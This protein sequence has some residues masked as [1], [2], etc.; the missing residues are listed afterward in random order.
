MANGLFY[1]YF[2]DLREVVAELAGD[3]FDELRARTEA[4]DESASDY[5]WLYRNHVNVVSLFA[6]N[7]GIL[8]CLFGL[9]GDYDEYDAI[10]KRNAHD[11]NLTVAQFLMDRAGCDEARAERMAFV[12]GA[13]TEGI[14]YQS[15][16]RRTEDLY[17]FGDR[18][19]AIAEVIAVIW[20]RT[21][22]LRDPDQRELRAAGASLCEPR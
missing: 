2:L 15:L 20:Y 5:A 3:L 8:A 10:W 9:A 21:I 14:I 13:V 16:I 11:W 1:H 18:P 17:Q 6:E 7:P 19:E 4:L 22:F 12:L